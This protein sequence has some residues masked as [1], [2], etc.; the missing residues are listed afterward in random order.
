MRAGFRIRGAR[1]GSARSPG[2]DDAVIDYLSREESVSAFLAHVC[3]AGG[4]ERGHLS[5]ARILESD[6]L[7][8][9]HRRAASV[10]VPGRA[11]GEA[12]ARHGGVDVVLRHVE[13][14][15]MH[16]SEEVPWRAESMKAM[17]LAAG[18]GTR[19]RPLTNDRPK[20]LVTVG[21]RTMLEIALARLRQLRRERSDRE[22]ASLR[23]D[24]SRVPEGQQQLRHAD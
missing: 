13:L 14:E 8:R 5:A 15:K 10:G 23:R 1:S 3:C 21:G 9:L 17:V 6:G 22:Y 12:F 18:L 20:A 7:V 4:C 2:R 24:D 11:T 19:L 16:R